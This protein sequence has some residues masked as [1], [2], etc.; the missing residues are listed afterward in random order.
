MRLTNQ[1]AHRSSDYILKE[2]TNTKI[3]VTNY[4]II[5]NNYKIIYLQDLI[6]T[7]NS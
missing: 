2:K 5:Q 3:P 4:V 7:D 6:S 1:F